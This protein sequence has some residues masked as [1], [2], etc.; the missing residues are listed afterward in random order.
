LKEEK[1]QKT[2][3]DI[4]KYSKKKRRKAQ[5][6]EQQMMMFRNP[7]ATGRFSMPAVAEVQKRNEKKI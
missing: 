4:D 2:V 5:K 3:K 6:L 7:H 1:R